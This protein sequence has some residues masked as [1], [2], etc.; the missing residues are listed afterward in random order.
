MD[1]PIC[2]GTIYTHK[3][4]R[5][6]LILYGAWASCRVRFSHGDWKRTQKIKSV[7]EGEQK[8]RAETNHGDVGHVAAGG[9]CACIIVC[10]TD[11]RARRNLR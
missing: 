9:A 1:G 5:A 3:L 6:L 2:L 8:V 10:F 11:A 4:V 7:T